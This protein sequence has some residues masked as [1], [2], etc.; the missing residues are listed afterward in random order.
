MRR[1]RFEGGEGGLRVSTNGPARVVAILAPDGLRLHAHHAEPLLLDWGHFDVTVEWLAATTPPSWQL[2]DWTGSRGGVGGLAIRLHGPYAPLGRRLIRES[3]PPLQRRPFGALILFLRG[4]SMVL[5]RQSVPLIPSVWPVSQSDRST[6]AALCSVLRD[7][8]DIRTRLGE[9]A[10]VLRLA[11]DLTTGAVNRPPPLPD[12]TAAN[13][14]LARALQRAGLAY[15]Y[16]RA[17]TAAD[18][19]TADDALARFNAEL[20]RVPG[21]ASRPPTQAAVEKFLTTHH[22]RQPWPFAALVEG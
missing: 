18:V 5:S 8:P 17:L 13:R 15:P 14:D 16:G 4:G 3:T 21:N 19:A 11:Q 12:G 2:A 6:L 1:M 10:R 22:A 9:P 7:R 20:R